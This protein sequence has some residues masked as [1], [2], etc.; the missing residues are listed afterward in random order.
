MRVQQALFLVVLSATAAYSFPT[1]GLLISPLKNQVLQTRCKL[2]HIGSKVLQHDHILGD[3]CEGSK[4]VE[5]QI[6]TSTTTTTTTTASEGIEKEKFIVTSE[7]YPSSL[8]IDIRMGPDG[9]TS[10]STPRET[11]RLDLAEGGEVPTKQ[12]NYA[13]VPPDGGKHVIKAKCNG[14]LTTDGCLEEI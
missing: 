5:Q 1:F 4:A 3:P 14:V 2:H 11:T 13:T 8:D 7:A 10:S 6:T 12:K 9:P